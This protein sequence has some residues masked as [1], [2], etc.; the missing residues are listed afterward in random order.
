MYLENLKIVWAEH[1]YAPVIE[2]LC[3]AKKLEEAVAV[4]EVMRSKDIPPTLETAKP[5][6]EMI[7][8]DDSALDSAWDIL[9]HMHE[10][11][12]KVDIVGLNLIIHASTFLNDLQRAIGTYKALESFNVKPNTETYNLLF[13]ACIKAQHRQLADRLLLEMQEAKIKPDAETYKSIILLC[14]TQKTYEDAFF[15]LEEM[16][17]QGIKPPQAIYE[18]I[19][20]KTVS[21]GD[22]RWHLALEE[23]KENGYEISRKLQQFIDSG[24]AAE[25]PSPSS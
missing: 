13:S 10:Q 17:A 11:G 8:V 25:S 4:L 12:R 14:L 18:A 15:Y 21:N 20:R 16:K 24:G 7:R 22:T 19:I 23:L 2:A 1:H 3:M 6:Y 9:E 5:I